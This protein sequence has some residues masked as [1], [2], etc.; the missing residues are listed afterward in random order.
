MKSLK[1]I[2]TKKAKRSKTVTKKLKTKKNKQNKRK[3]NPHS[4]T[5]LDINNKVYVNDHFG[6]A[7]EV[8]SISYNGNKLTSDPILYLTKAETVFRPQIKINHI[9]PLMLI[10]YDNDAPNGENEPENNANYMHMVEI[11]QNKEEPNTLLQYT[12]PTPPYGTH[13]Y[14]FE[15]YDLSNFNSNIPPGKAGTVYYN[16]I[17]KIIKDNKLSQVTNP[18]LFKVDSD[19]T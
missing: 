17:K 9:G 15:L 7:S 18:L 11:Y 14:I 10:M 13:N 5:Q 19:I 3:R 1:K 4:K 16:T 2:N 8:L 6:G 12:P